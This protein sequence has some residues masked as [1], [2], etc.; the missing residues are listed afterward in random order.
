MRSL[1]LESGNAAQ[2]NNPWSSRSNDE[3]SFPSTL[4]ARDGQRGDT[5]SVFRDDSLVSSVL[6]VWRDRDMILDPEPPPHSAQPTHAQPPMQ[7]TDT[8]QTDSRMASLKAIFPDFDDT[9]MFVNP[10]L[11]FL[12]WIAKPFNS[13]IPC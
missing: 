5:D 9:V 8:T 13:A 1:Q 7:G 12:S 4:T 10:T 2:I 11:V 6:T 3:D